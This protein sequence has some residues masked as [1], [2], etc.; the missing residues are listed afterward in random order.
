MIR[1]TFGFIW[2]LFSV[3]YKLIGWVIEGMIYVAALGDQAFL[4]VVYW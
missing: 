3:Y 1:V 4:V 2:V